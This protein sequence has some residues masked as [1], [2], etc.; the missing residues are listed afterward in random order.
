LS[1]ARADAVKNYLLAAGINSARIQA[2]G[3]GSF[4]PKA[5]NDTEEGRQTNRRV[6]FAIL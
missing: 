5:T 4:K 2:K 6:E 1:Q 3:Y